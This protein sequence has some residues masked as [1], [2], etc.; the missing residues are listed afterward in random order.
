MV[1]NISSNIAEHDDDDKSINKSYTAGKPEFADTES[2]STKNNNLLE[3]INPVVE[4]A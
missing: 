2:A 3:G 4:N 1:L